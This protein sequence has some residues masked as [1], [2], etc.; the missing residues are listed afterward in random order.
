M[1]SQATITCRSSK[2]EGHALAVPKE[3]PTSIHAPVRRN[4]CKRK[5]SEDSASDVVFSQKIYSRICTFG[6]MS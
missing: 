2:V 5:N 3:A 6:T 4:C 1:E